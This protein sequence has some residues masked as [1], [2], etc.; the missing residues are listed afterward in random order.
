MSAR[1]GIGSHVG[2]EVERIIFLELVAQARRCRFLCA[3]RGTVGGPLAAWPCLLLL[4]L[5]LLLGNVVNVHLCFLAASLGVMQRRRMG[6]EDDAPDGGLNAT[7]PSS[8]PF[9][10]RLIHFAEGDGSTDEEA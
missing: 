7:L 2:F 5:L 3:N 6:H 10:P 8:S 4:L 9:P 1:T